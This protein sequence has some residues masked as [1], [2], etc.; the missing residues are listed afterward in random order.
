MHIKSIYIDVEP[1]D[2]YWEGNI[3]VRVTVKTEEGVYHQRQMFSDHH[4]I[5]MYDRL[6][7][8]MTE[9]IKNYI[10]NEVKNGPKSD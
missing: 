9:Q 5:S 4:F 3:T 6:M 1:Q 2:D 8:Q 7:A 10:F